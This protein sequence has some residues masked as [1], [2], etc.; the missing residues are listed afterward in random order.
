MLGPTICWQECW[1]ECMHPSFEPTRVG[2]RTHPPPPTPSINLQV[3]EA[4]EDLLEEVAASLDLL[5]R[6]AVLRICDGNMQARVLWPAGRGGG[7]VRANCLCCG[8]GLHGFSSRLPPPFRDLKLAM[9]APP[10]LHSSTSSSHLPSLQCLVKVLE[11]CKYLLEALSRGGY[12][13]SDYE[14]L[15]LLP[16]VV[17]KSGHNQVGGWEGLGALHRWFMWPRRRA[18]CK[19][20]V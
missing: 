16:A 17:E 20:G 7:L 11:M 18:S 14:A 2:K 3:I 6:W 15:L 8:S 1:R 13:L 9:Q 19:G 12:Q 5:L 4:L 10:C